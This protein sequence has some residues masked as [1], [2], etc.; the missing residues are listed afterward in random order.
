MPRLSAVAPELISELNAALLEEG[1]VAVSHQLNDLMLSEVTIDDAVHMGYIYVQHP[2]LTED[3]WAK[4]KE[5]ISTVAFAEPYLFNIDLD[6]RNRIC[7]IEFAG[8][9]G[10]LH[11]L[12]SLK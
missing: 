12:A 5:S 10:L 8:R 7:G 11:Y 9:N 4:A 6:N 2:N 1:L 3:R